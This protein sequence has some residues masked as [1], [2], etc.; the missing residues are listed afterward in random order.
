[1]K[2][3]G[4]AIVT[5]GARGIGKAIVEQLAS[6]GYNVVINYVSDGSQAKAQ[7]IIDQ[8]KA[9]CGVDGIAVQADVSSYEACK[10]IVE[11]GVEAFGDKISILVNNAGTDVGCPFVQTPIEQIDN[12]IQVNLNSQMYMTQLVLPYMIGAKA[13]DIINISSIGGTWGV[14]LHVHYCAAKA[15]VLGFTKALA[16]EVAALGVKVNAIAPGVIMT[17]LVASEPPEE[18]EMT[19][20]MT[21]MQSIGE[22]EEIAWAVSYLVKS[23]FM[24]GQIISPNGGLVI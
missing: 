8:I 5:G 17:D 16:K 15:G 13:G 14:P 7:A 3:E 4:F 18:V 11:A 9:D 12:M 19:K 6:E 1:M 20:A 2:N 22:P 24:T 23:D 21:P 10:S